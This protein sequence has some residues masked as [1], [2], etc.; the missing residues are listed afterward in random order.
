MRTTTVSRSS[1]DLGISIPPELRGLHTV[2]GWPRLAVDALHER[3]DVEGF[4]LSSADDA[5]EGLWEVWQGNNLDEESPAGA[6]GC[7]GVRPLVC[8]GRDRG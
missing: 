5:D 8:A 4:R 1:T 6:P 2:M 3:M 7:D